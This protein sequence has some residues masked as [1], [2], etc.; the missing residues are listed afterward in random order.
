VN[1]DLTEDLKYCLQVVW[2]GF[3]Y[4]ICYKMLIKHSFLCSTESQNK[5]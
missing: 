1:N 2:T 4:F 3:T 5:G